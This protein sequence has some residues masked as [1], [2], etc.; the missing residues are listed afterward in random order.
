[1]GMQNERIVAGN[2]L[3]ETVLADERL[4]VVPLTTIRETVA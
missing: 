2:D 4:Q 3:I 1:M